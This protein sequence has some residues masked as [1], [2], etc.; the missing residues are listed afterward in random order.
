LAADCTAFA[1]SNFHHRFLKNNSIAIACPK[2][3]NATDFYVEK[4]TAM[5]DNSLIHTLSVIIMEVP[6]CRG[7][8]QIAQQAQA[9]AKRKIT[10]KKIVIGTKGNL[11]S[12]E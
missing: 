9:R 10:I 7:L 5:I 3:D 1:Y 4:L 2:L 6:C 11:Q 8:F 12:E